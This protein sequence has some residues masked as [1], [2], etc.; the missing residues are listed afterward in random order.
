MD[1]NYELEFHQPKLN[2]EL[3]Q[4]S[5]LFSSEP[6]K[7]MENYINSRQNE[8]EIIRNHFR[9]FEFAHDSDSDNDLRNNNDS[10]SNKPVFVSLFYKLSIFRLGNHC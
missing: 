2:D 10:E 3:L 7:K 1:L 9:S 4:I 5:K 8:L 6:K